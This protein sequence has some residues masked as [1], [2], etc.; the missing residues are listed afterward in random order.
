MRLRD[1]Y[2]AAGEF[3]HSIVATAILWELLCEEVEFRKSCTGSRTTGRIYTGRYCR[4]HARSR[5][6]GSCWKMRDTGKAT[7]TN[8]GK[9]E[10]VRHSKQV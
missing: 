6:C 4:Y 1:K 7:E 2:V 8:A 3:V 10:Q 9:H 5:K